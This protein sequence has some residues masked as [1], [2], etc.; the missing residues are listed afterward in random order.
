VCVRSARFSRSGLP[1]PLLS[2]DLRH[3]CC[4]C[5]SVCECV[6]VCTCVIEFNAPHK[7]IKRE[8]R[9]SRVVS[10]EVVIRSCPPCQHFQTLFLSFCF[11]TLSLSRG[12]S[13]VSPLV[14]FIALLAG[15][16]PPT[17]PHLISSDTGLRNDCGCRHF[18]SFK[19]LPLLPSSWSAI[20][21]NKQ[22]NTLLDSPPLL[23]PPFTVNHHSSFLS[24]FPCLF[25]LAPQQ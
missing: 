3:R 21:T 2:I 23:S 14:V 12:V 19:P 1:L 20:H 8:R 24:W 7:R 16:A 5:M 17:A 11:P 6:C 9:T 10:F 25:C 15:G 13:S 22:T 4:V 18:L